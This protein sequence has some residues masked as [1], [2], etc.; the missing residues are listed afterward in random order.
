[1]NSLKIIFHYKLLYAV[2]FLLSS[3][4]A[5]ATF[6]KNDT[7]HTGKPYKISKQKFLARYGKDDSSRALIRYYFS[8]RKG[9]RN[10]ALLYTA[11]AG[12]GYLILN[13][14]VTQASGRDVAVTG[15]GVFAVLLGTALA[16]AA[17]IVAYRWL[18]TSRKRLFSMLT[19]YK[20][21][22]PI[23]EKIIRSSSFQRFLIQEK[24]K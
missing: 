5:L 21:G 10:S 20:M 23:P 19:D 24:S 8:K 2:I 7:S 11:L 17:P 14:I 22:M 13:A 12:A 15:T 1:M 18:R 4:H 9:L 3:F 16:L 6:S